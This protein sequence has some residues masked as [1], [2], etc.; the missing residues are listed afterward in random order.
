MSVK[1]RL[2][3]FIKYKKLSQGR[4][5]TACGL[6]NGYVN[7][8]RQSIQ[9]DKLQKIALQFP[10]LNT[11]WL[12]AGEGSMLK[13]TEPSAVKINLED[14]NIRLVPLVSQYA[15]AGYLSGFADK[16]YIE[17]LP[18]VPFIVDKELNGNYIC[19]EVKG[20]SMDDR[21]INSY[22]EGSLVLA[23]EVRQD[24]WKS[25]LHYKDWDFVIVHREKG[26]VIKQ[27]TEHHVE[28]AIITCHSLNSMY[29]DFELHLKDVSQIFNV[30]KKILP[31]KR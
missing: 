31:A 17:T 24:F 15:Y 12:M 20:D 25:K 13:E 23:R 7:N 5:E 9:P 19:F 6:S 29:D 8:I 27:I 3:L 2:T 18:T 30:V 21:S 4:F 16:Q 11:G 10:E 1:E 22:P 28:N 14:S 26:I